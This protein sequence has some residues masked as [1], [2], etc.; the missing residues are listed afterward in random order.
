[1]EW[2]EIIEQTEEYVKVKYYPEQTKAIGE[3]GVVK[4][5]FDSDKWIFEKLAN[6]YA[7]SYAMHACNFVRQP[8]KHGEKIPLCGIAAWH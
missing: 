2:V 4:Y 8:Y 3:Y 5:F 1:M 7:T 6:S